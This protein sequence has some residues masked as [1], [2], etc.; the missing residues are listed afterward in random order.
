MLRPLIKCAKGI[1]ELFGF[2]G[3]YRCF[4]YSWLMLCFLTH[5]KEQQKSDHDISINYF[6]TLKITARNLTCSSALHIKLTQFFHQR[7]AAHIQALGGMSNHAITL[8]QG[9]TY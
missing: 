8:I 9:L 3:R 7:S 5:S 4:E 2:F 6:N 1:G